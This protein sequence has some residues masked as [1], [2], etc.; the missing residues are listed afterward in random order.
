MFEDCGLEFMP[1]SNQVST[2]AL[3]TDC[4]LTIA[5]EEVYKVIREAQSRDSIP[6]AEISRSSGSGG[7][8][9]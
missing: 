3:T 5:T 9:R 8:G 7:A 6:D 4:E 1:T 2:R